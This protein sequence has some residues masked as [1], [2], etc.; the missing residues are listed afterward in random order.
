MLDLPPQDRGHIMA[1]VDR[2]VRPDVPETRMRGFE[3][4]AEYTM[5]KVRERRDAPGVDLVSRLT[6]A[7]IEG[8]P[9][10]AFELQGLMSVLMLAG[11]DTVASMLTF[12]ARFL[13]HSPGHRRRLLADPAIRTDAI[14]EFLRRM[15]MVNLTRQARGDTMLDGAPVRAGDL[16]VAPLALANF[17]R[18]GQDWLSVDFDRPRLQHATFGAGVHYCP[19]SMLAR[20]EIRIFLEEWLP[21]I[22]DFAVAEGAR[23]EVKVG[24]AV[25]IPRLPLVWS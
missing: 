4:L 17:P 14:E 12:I 9:L 2:I 19:G 16:V 6:T 23:L 18:D 25:M 15:P 10:E 11:L 13:A 3:E 5:G 24:A 20:T 7:E 21:R 1:I 8:R 22:P